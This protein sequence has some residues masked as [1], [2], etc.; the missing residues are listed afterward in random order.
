MAI[1]KFV[2]LSDANMKMF[3]CYTYSSC[4]RSEPVLKATDS[5]REL[6]YA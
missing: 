3:E 2:M 5:S 4:T 1:N 6:R